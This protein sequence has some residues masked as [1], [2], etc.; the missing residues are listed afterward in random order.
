MKKKKKKAAE[1]EEIVVDLDD[2]FYP[3]H[4]MHICVS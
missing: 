2:T 1:E 4:P 3:P